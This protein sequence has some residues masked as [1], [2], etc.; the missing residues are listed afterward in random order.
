MK[1]KSITLPPLYDHHSHYSLYS[2][3]SSMPSLAGIADRSVAC[4]IIRSSINKDLTIVR[5]WNSSSFPLFQDDLKNME[6]VIVLN[7]SLHGLIMNNSAM[8]FLSDDYHDLVLNHSDS[9]WMEKNLPQIL[10]IITKIASPSPCEIS[11]FGESLLNEGISCMEDMLLPAPEWLTLISASPLPVYF[12]ADDKVYVTLDQSEKEKIKGVKIFTDGALGTKTAALS[13]PYDSGENGLLLH[14][15][16]HLVAELYDYMKNGIPVSLHSIG[17][18]ATDQ[19]IKIISMLRRENGCGGAVRIEHAQFIT[20][21]NA[22][23]ARDAGITLSMQPNFSDDS[24]MY[25]DRLPSGF[26]EITIPSG[27]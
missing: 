20:R 23:S 13:S 25:A 18:M 24:V 21:E 14:E 2:A 19:V 7:L 8:E 16:E 15:D 10:G 1:M 9:I 22:R 3:L 12:W 26:A 17:D 27:C 6:P 11:A 4:E 5:G